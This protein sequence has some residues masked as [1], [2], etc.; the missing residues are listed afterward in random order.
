MKS[1]FDFSLP[2]RQSL[3]G[4]MVLFVNTLQKTV[5]AFWPMLVVV[6]FKKDKYDILY[7]YFGVFGVVF[8]VAII[9]FLRYW[10]FKF[11]IDYKLE[12]F[13]I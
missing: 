1:N 12:E 2:Q 13:V 5:R 9:A 3:I 8:L 6:L 4:V 11:Y 7:I 10:F